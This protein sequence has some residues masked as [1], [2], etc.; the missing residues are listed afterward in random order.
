[1][2]HCSKSVSVAKF[3]IQ[4][5]LK[6]YILLIEVQTYLFVIKGLLRQ[7]EGSIPVFPAGDQGVKP[8]TGWTR[9]LGRVILYLQINSQGSSKY[10]VRV[11]FILIMVDNTTTY[12]DILND[13]NENNKSY[14]EHFKPW[15]NPF[16]GKKTCTTYIWDMQEEFRHNGERLINRDTV[17]KALAKRNILRQ[18]KTTQISTNLKFVSLEFE[19]PLIMDTFCREPLN[20]VDACLVKFKPDYTKLKPKQPKKY[21]IISFFNVPAELDLQLLTDFLDQFA[22]IEGTPRY[23]TRTYNDIQYKTG[24]ITYKIT[25]ILQDIPRYNRLFG[26]SIKCYYDG[27]PQPSK[28]QRPTEYNSDDAEDN[29]I[30]TQIFQQPEQAENTMNNQQNTEFNNDNSNNQIHINEHQQPQKENNTILEENKQ[31]QKKNNR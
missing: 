22:T 8:E 24:T 15:E 30:D 9:T 23:T 26:R 19:N 5:V 3:L 16:V 7:Q 29:E 28:K 17:A 11:S 27:Q 14:W 1:M 10:S 31:Q 13:D 25:S 18:T 2:Y 6:F 4:F 12:R 20:I 21:T